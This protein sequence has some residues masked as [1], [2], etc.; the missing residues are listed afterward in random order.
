LK[1]T[2]RLETLLA[3]QAFAQ[4][5]AHKRSWSFSLYRTFSVSRQHIPNF[6]DN[7]E[8]LHVSSD[9]DFLGRLPRWPNLADLRLTFELYEGD[10]IINLNCIPRLF[11]KLEYLSLSDPGEYCGS[12]MGLS[13]LKTFSLWN[14]TRHNDSFIPFASCSTL[15]V[16]KFYNCFSFD[17][18]E[19]ADQP[20]FPR[21]HEFTK[22]ER[23]TIQPLVEGA[24]VMFNTTAF[25]LKS[26]VV[27]LKLQ[28]DEF[29][30]DIF[31]RPGLCHLQNLVLSV[32]V[33]TSF[34]QPLK[35]PKNACEPILGQITGE[36]SGLKTLCIYMSFR[37][38]W[39]H[40]FQN[41]G[42]LTYLEWRVEQ[43]Y[44]WLSREV[45]SLKT[46]KEN[47]MKYVEMFYEAFGKIEFVSRP[48]IVLR[49]V[50][51]VDL[52]D[53]LKHDMSI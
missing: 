2:Q 10:A 44:P 48:E 25:S 18:L 7:V 4:R 53:E 5:L 20:R 30:Q 9:R 28:K 38:S 27:T 14:V 40:H 34:Y 23:M 17:P 31:N 8:R 1:L 49:A 50:N 32:A 26:L 52:V 11:P 42:E 12:L 36:L 43:P 16:I 46:R 51:G 45:R 35:Q 22:L 15:K 13:G 39:A 6:T 41:L 19:G 3:D 24:E 29:T 33:A 21:L 47:N 37:P